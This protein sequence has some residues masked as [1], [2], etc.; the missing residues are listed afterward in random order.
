MNERRL[1]HRCD[2]ATSPLGF[3]RTCR[4]ERQRQAATFVADVAIVANQWGGVKWRKR[5]T[6]A[7]GVRRRAGRPAPGDGVGSEPIGLRF[8]ADPVVQSM[9]ADPL[10]SLA[11]RGPTVEHEGRWSLTREGR[12]EVTQAVLSLAGPTGAAQ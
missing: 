9:L 10:T 8:A 11:K 2:I 5:A 1:R 12:Q 3:C 7:A 6:R 4:T